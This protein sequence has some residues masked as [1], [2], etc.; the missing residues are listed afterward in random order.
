MRRAISTLLA[1][2]W[3]V[4]TI[5][6]ACSGVASASADDSRLLPYGPAAHLWLLP[7]AGNPAPA[8]ALAD[9]LAVKVRVRCADRADGAREH[10]RSL[11]SVIFHAPL[12]HDSLH[13]RFGPR[14]GG[15]PP[16]P[17]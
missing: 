10:A 5:A 12:A 11:D 14:D 2:L 16:L 8:K 17:A 15:D 7:K 1:A 9:R 4:L 13:R 6:L 3:V